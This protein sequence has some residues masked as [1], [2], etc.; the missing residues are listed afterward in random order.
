M[1]WTDNLSV[2][3][4]NNTNDTI[5]M[6]NNK[7]KKRRCESL[8]LTSRTASPWTTSSSAATT[9]STSSSATKI[10]ELNSC[11]NR[12]KPLANNSE[13]YYSS[14]EPWS[15]SSISATNDTVT[16]PIAQHQ[17]LLYRSHPHDSSMSSSEALSTTA[18]PSLSDR[19]DEDDDNDECNYHA[20]CMRRK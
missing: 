3:E 12:I 15:N 13:E 4:S 8:M 11:K 18:E 9:I 5:F 19:D 1:L 2:A 10:S 17:H 14:L 20:N 6:F 16:S 7:S